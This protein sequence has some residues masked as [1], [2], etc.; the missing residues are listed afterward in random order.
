MKPHDVR[1]FDDATPSLRKVAV[2]RLLR[3]VVHADGGPLIHNGSGEEQHSPSKRPAAN[4]PLAQSTSVLSRPATH[5]FSKRGK[6][7]VD[8]LERSDERPA[9]AG[10]VPYRAEA[11]ASIAVGD[12]ISRHGVLN[13]SQRLVPHGFVVANLVAIHQRPRFEL[14]KIA[15]GHGCL[16]SVNAV[17]G[18]GELDR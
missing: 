3:E 17:V 10:I 7:L 18:Q 4:P 2:Q 15:G 5:R 14:Y 13:G 12:R 16:G 8:G 11:L 9:V 1:T 6:N